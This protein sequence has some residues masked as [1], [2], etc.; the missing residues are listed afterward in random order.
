MARHSNLIS[1]TSKADMKALG[2]KLEGGMI[3][4]NG[5]AFGDLPLDYTDKDLFLYLRGMSAVYDNK[6]LWFKGDK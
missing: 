4:K 1:R 2:V 6:D 5:I 3:F